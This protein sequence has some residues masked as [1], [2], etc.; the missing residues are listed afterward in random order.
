MHA[1]VVQARALAAFLI[2]QHVHPQPAVHAVQ[3]TILIQIHAHFAHLHAP[4]ASRI[5]KH[6]RP[7][8]APPVLQ[9]TIKVLGYAIPA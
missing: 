9:A 6:V 8:H 2:A 7:L 3:A 4:A 1:V 5:A